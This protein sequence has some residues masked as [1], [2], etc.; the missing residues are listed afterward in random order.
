[1]GGRGTALHAAGPRN[2]LREAKREQAPALQ[3]EP[4]KSLARSGR[5]DG[6]RR[7]YL[8]F[9]TMASLVV[10]M[11]PTSSSISFWGTR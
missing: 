5:S 4:P 3:G 7:P 2:K 6:L 1:M 11:I 8:A 9:S 10:A